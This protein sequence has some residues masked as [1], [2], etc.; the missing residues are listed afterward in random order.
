MVRSIVGTLLEI[1]LGHRPVE[2]MHRLIASKD[3]VQA[4][5]AA[6]AKGLFLSQIEYPSDIYLD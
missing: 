4:G 2:D 3:R 5:K 6:P 1:G